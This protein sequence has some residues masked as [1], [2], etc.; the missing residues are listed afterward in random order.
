MPQ[1]SAAPNLTEL[2]RALDLANVI[3]HEIDG[4]ILHWTTGCERLYGRSKREATGEVV[5][6]LLATTYPQPRNKIIAEL[7]KRGRW[8]GELQHRRRDG[9]AV[10]IAGLWVTQRAKGN[11][12]HC[13]L[14]MNYDITGLK[15]AQTD[16]VA[17][18]AHL[19]SILDTVPEAMI[20]IDESGSSPRLAPRPQTCSAIK[21]KRL[22]GKT[23]RC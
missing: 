19:R 3:I 7:R 16:L 14:Q 5:H 6:D 9:A 1:P 23:S 15:Q 2:A 10:S 18:E 22:S 21:R 12:I 17:R 4:A 13:V 20:V 11:K 8:Q